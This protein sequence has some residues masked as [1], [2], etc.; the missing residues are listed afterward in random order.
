MKFNQL[1]NLIIL[2]ILISFKN[3]AQNCWKKV[4]QTDLHTIALKNNGTIW[5]WGRNANGQLGNGENGDTS[6]PKLMNDESDWTDIDAREFYTVA[7]KEDNSLWLWGAYRGNTPI[8]FVD[9]SEVGWKKIDADGYIGLKV[10]GTI[11][12]WYD[13]FDPSENLIQVGKFNFWQDISSGSHS[14]LAIASNGTLWAWGKN[15][16]GIFGNGN[17]SSHS[18]STQ[19]YGSSEPIQIGTSND[20]K[21]ISAGQQFVLAIKEDNSLWAWGKNTYGQFGNGTTSDSFVPIKIGNDKDWIDIKVGLYHSLALKS[22]GE[23]YSWG[24][25]ASGRLG[26]G[27]NSS[28]KTPKKIGL[29]SLWKKINASHSNSVLIDNY[30]EVWTAGKNNYGQ[31]GNGKFFNGYVRSWHFLI[32]FGCFGSSLGI[33]KNHIT[34][35][36]IYPNPTFEKIYLRNYETIEKIEI[37]NSLGQLKEIFTNSKTINISKYNNGLYLLKIKYVNGTTT[38]KKIIKLG[39]N[40]YN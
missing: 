23:V 14:S 38:T 34:E 36:V 35:Q 37:Y 9:S 10:D 12:S 33:Y 13:I 20:W 4:V 15:Y 6:T 26:N 3:H 28:T 30:G 16:N 39:K 27:S 31:L 17:Q 40:V 29:F 18:D 2:L 24:D 5:S 1:F 11:W 19:D 8:K 22:N 32:K 21:K 7:T 25:D